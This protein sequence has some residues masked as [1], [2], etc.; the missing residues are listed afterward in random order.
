MTVHDFRI[1][2]KRLGL[3]QTPI[4]NFQTTALGYRDWALNFTPSVVT[5]M[6]TRLQEQSSTLDS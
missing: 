2:I 3:K 4:Q 5:Q 6:R 1:E